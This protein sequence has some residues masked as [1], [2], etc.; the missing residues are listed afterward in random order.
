MVFS[1]KESCSMKEN[2]SA[3]VNWNYVALSILLLTVLTLMV[4]YMPN[5]REI[6]MVMLK[7]IRKFFDFC[8]SYVPLFFSNYGG[9]GN[10][11]WPQFTASVVLIS[12][13]KYLKA[14]MLVFFTQGAYILCDLIK[15]FV[16]RE[17]PSLHL[18]YSFPS[19]HTTTQTCFYGILIYLVLYYVRNTF[20]RVVLSVLF[21]LM[22]VCVGLSR[23]LLN[24]HFPID[25]LAG[26]SLGFLAVN[27]YI[28]LD[29]FFSTR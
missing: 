15:N 20:W 21:G 8:P 12:H 11:I 19:G 5:L 14:F 9:V 22:I 2:N 28:I 4:L 16:C 17:R 10:F 27:L 29:K 26:M 1:I 24:V 25:I 6:D 7:A 23:M 18:G 13:K 3:V